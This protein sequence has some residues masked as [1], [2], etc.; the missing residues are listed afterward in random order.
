MKAKEYF[1]KYVNEY[2]G[3]SNDYKVITILRD[4]YCEA[5]DIAKQRNSQSNET[6]KAIF[7]ELNQ[8][9]NSFCLMVNEIDNMNMK[10][11]ALM[12]LIQI[13]SPVLYKM[14]VNENN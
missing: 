4:I 9:A 5:K 3:Y 7:K 11:D 2:Q 10:K 8:K 12:L 13:E 1:E 6:Y 14:L